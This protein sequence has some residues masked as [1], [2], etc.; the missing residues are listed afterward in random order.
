MKCVVFTDHKSL[1]YIL[2]QKE[3]NIRQC[4]WLEILSDY[5]CEIR[6]KAEYQKP[7]GLLLQL[8]I[9]EWKW[10]NIMMDFVTK[11]LKTTTGQGM[12]W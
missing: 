9:L 3:L 11:L 1:Q 2:D 8:E 12:I 4:R 10:E 7:S 5:D 6:V